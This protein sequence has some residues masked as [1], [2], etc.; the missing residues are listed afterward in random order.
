[1]LHM[2]VSLKGQVVLV[3]G[4]SSGIGRET[5][6]LFAREGARVV[7]SARRGDRLRRLQEELTKEGHHIDISPGDTANAGEMEQLAQRAGAIDI[8]VYAA[9]TN[10]PDR[11]MKR[12]NTQIWDMM[13]SV[14]LNGA[15]YITRAV[16]PRMR[17]AG[18]GHLIYISSISGLVPDVSGA[19]YQAA[20]RGLLGLAHAIRVEEKENGIRTCVICP[21]L[22][23]TEILEKRPVKPSAEMLAK[24]LRPEDVAEAVL[25]VAK[26]P[27]RAVVPEMQLLPTY[28]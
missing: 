18:A 25:S 17:E 16:L 5:A 8:L 14:N 9:G 23:D 11:A 19:A 3:V 12:L 27:A 24:A 26:L 15:Y 20:K 22:V 21:G 6:I 13:L 1:V 7:A 2:P 10:T 4:A 28:L